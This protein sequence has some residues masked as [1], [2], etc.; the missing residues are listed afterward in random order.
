MPSTS[1]LYFFDLLPFMPGLVTAMV[2]LPYNGIFTEWIRV[3]FGQ[4]ALLNLSPRNLLAVNSSPS[5]A[6]NSKQKSNNNASS[7]VG[8][9]G[10]VHSGMIKE[11]KP[12]E[13][14]SNNVQLMLLQRSSASKVGD[15]A[16]VEAGGGDVVDGEN[17]K[18]GRLFDLFR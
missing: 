9:G 1:V 2:F 12:Y 3:L 16:A 4:N 10:S 13:S 15:V 11:A 5:N 6:S 8:G 7:G 18:Q 17:M 14:L